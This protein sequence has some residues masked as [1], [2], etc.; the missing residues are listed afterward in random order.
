M[1]RIRFGAFYPG[2]RGGIAP[3]EFARRAEDLGFDSVWAGEA[4]T[5]RGPIYDAFTTLCF[6]AATTS[7]IA[8]GAD[9]LLLPLH[10]P[11]WV[12][13]QFGTLDVISGG[14]S[15]LGVGVGGQYAKQFEAFGVQVHER[16]RR[17]DE[18]IE[19]IKALWTQSPASYSGR[20]YTFEGIEMEPRPVQQPHP[21]IWVGG[22]PGG[23]EQGP[24][25]KPR[26]KS[27]TAAMDRAAKYADG[28]DP[29]YMTPEMYRDS[30]SYIRRSAAK[31]GRDV[32][33]IEWALTTHWLIRDSYDD[34]LE[35]AAKRLRYGRDLAER[36]GRYDILGSPADIIKRL[37]QYVDAGV[38][39][40]ICNWSCP[41]EEAAAHIETI[42]RDVIPAFR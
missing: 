22:R 1:E 12:A 42:A 2:Q 38:R 8:I 5:N 11:S 29:F 9:V 26:F 7:R 16:G 37:E 4:P 23:T 39:H 14:R 18:G 36:V 31:L 32:S 28:W 33:S 15:I 13:K 21:P 35:Q 3:G 30:V 41:P 24:G 19:A 27:K 6:L 34:A 40:F 20:H 10:H 25:G 17:T